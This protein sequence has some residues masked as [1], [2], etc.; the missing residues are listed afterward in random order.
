MADWCY[1][2]MTI[3]MN[4]RVAGTLPAYSGCR[5]AVPPH[6]ALYPVPSK[7]TITLSL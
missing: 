3:L 2:L 6:Q 7:L 5:K 1:D 4:K